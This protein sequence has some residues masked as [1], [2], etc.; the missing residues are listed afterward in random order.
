[1]HITLKTIN[2]IYQKT[3]Q[4]GQ[5][6][7]NSA[8]K[9]SREGN[10]GKV[11]YI[12]LPDGSLLREIT[13]KNGNNISRQEFLLGND[14]PI[15]IT[16]KNKN[17]FV[18]IKNGGKDKCTIFSKKTKASA[19][20]Q[21]IDDATGKKTIIQDSEQTLIK[22]QNNAKKAAQKAFSILFNQ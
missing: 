14:S 6:I 7:Q 16:Y 11:T 9:F 13:T 4:K 8:K 2:N 1:M 18:S 17:N 10:N 22:I 15:K 12:A 20:Q 3:L 5:S 21:F 19:I